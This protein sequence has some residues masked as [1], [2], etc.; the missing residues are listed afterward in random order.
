[1]LQNHVLPGNQ[2][3]YTRLCMCLSQLPSFKILFAADQ[4]TDICIMPT[5]DAIIVPQTGKPLVKTT[6]PI[7]TPKEGELLVKISSAGLNPHDQKIRDFNLFELGTPSI[8]AID[9]VGT[10]AAV[11]SGVQRFKIGDRV[12][13]QS[14][15]NID[16]A[17][18]QQ[19]ALLDYRVT[20]HVPDNI[21]DDEAATLPDNAMAPFVAFFHSSG[22]GLPPPFPD[23]EDAKKFDYGAQSIVIIGGGSNTGKFGVQFAALAGIGNIIVVAS[24]SNS[25]ELKSYGATHI[26]DRHLPNEEIKARIQSI[27]GDKQPNVLDTITMD[28]AL[29]ISLVSSAKNGKVRTLLPVDESLGKNTSYTIVQTH[30]NSHEYRDSIGAAF[31]KQLPDWVASGK[32]KPLSFKVVDGGLNAGGANK[33]L[34]DYRDGKNPGKWHLHPNA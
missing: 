27:T 5:Q 16:N 14:K 2:D 31:W 26:I 8:L 9:I 29:A 3:I 13:S 6:R 15:A 30:G 22:F 7:P 25:E 1:M 10:V 33:V 17:G 19:Y 24:L 18:L 12:F 4:Q 32:I 34:D 11:G 23:D 21:S 28:H 20:G